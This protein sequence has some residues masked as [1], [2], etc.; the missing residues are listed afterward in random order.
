MS[1]PRPAALLDTWVRRS[2]ELVTSW[3]PLFTHSVVRGSSIH[4]WV[5]CKCSKSALYSFKV[6]YQI[7]LCSR[8]VEITWIY[9]RRCSVSFIFHSPGVCVCVFHSSR[10]PRSEA[11]Q[12]SGG[13][14]VHRSYFLY[15]VSLSSSLPEKY[16]KRPISGGKYVSNVPLGY[17]DILPF[18]MKMMPSYLSRF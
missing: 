8:K 14:L 18:M 3:H 16:V 6:T 15:P 10:G 11:L 2:I 5:N 9:P 13:L 1:C 12:Q 7:S 17:V 4:Y